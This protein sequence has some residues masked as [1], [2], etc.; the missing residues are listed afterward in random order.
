MSRFHCLGL[1]WA[2]LTRKL[3][4]SAQMEDPLPLGD[5]PLTRLTSALVPFGP[6][7]A[8]NTERYINSN[9]MTPPNNI[10]AA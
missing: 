8:P 6:L 4:C 3:R 1:T 2:A 10:R 5:L 9:T 7:D